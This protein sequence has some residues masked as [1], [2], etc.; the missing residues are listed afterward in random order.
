MADRLTV[1]PSWLPT[2]AGEPTQIRVLTGHTD[3]VVDVATAPDGT[4]LASASD[5]QTAQIWDS[6][7]G[8]S[9]AVLTGHTAR[10]TSIAIAPDS[11]LSRQRATTVRRGRRHTMYERPDPQ[12]I[13]DRAAGLMGLSAEGRDR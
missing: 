3:R 1:Q 8:A 12:E 10:L 4:W 13:A 5:D 11:A 9:R 2:D 6:A 7:T